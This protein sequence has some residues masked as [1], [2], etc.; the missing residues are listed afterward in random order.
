MLLINWIVVAIFLSPANGIWPFDSNDSSSESVG[1]T[2]ASASNTAASSTTDHGLLGG[3]A[4]FLG[5]GDD[6]TSSTVLVA[7]LSDSSSFTM[8]SYA[9]STLGINAYQPFQTNCPSHKLVREA[10]ELSDQEQEYI[11]GRQEITNTNLIDFLTN[12]ANLTDFDA[13]SFINSYS[14]SHNITIGLTFSGGGY[15]AMLAGAGEIL[16]LDDRFDDSNSH[17]LG[18]LLQSSTYL[19]GLS[20]GNWLVGTLVLN[21][22]ISMADIFDGNISIWDLEDS[23]FNPSGINL[24][25]TVSY[26][27]SIE[28]AILAK[29]DA[30]F[31]T[32]ITDIWGRALSHQ[33]LA[34]DSGGENLTWSSIRDMDNFKNHQMP[35]PIVIAN[36]RT[37]QT[38]I[39][40][41]N[42][43]VFEIS[44]YELGSWDPSLKYFVDTQYLGS[45]LVNGDNKTEQCVMNFDNA[46][47]IMGTSSSLFN[48]IIIYASTSGLPDLVKTVLDK[49]LGSLS[50]DE[51]DIAA[52]SPNPFYGA[53]KAGIQTIVDNSTLFLVDGGEDAQNVP[54]YPLI[55]NNRQVDVI[56][57]FDNS[58]DS[59][60]NWPNCTSI[61]HTYL[62]QFAKQGKGTPFPYVPDVETFLEDEMNQRPY[63]FG[64]NSSD[65]S[66]LL[67]YHNNS[68]INATDIP[69]V[70]N[71]PNSHYSGQS[72]TS[73]FKMS[74]DED[75]RFGMYKNG[76]EVSTRG[77]L[78]ADSNWAK[79]VGCAIIRRSQERLGIEQSDECKDCFSEYC[80]K[81]L[82]ADAAYDEDFSSFV[83]SAGIDIGSP[84]ESSSP[85]ATSSATS[86][87]SG[88]TS[89]STSGSSESTS[90]SS[91]SSDLGNGKFK[92]FSKGLT[93][94]SIIISVL[95]Q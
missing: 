30:G 19:V 3:V 73:T 40:N 78:T 21:D 77:N 32:S 95:I 36:G 5:I 47:F 64:C 92:N 87:A 67:D 46:G 61:V 12:R 15:R 33:F 93:I 59:G 94:I 52:Y 35:F 53:E 79:C 7:T 24:M 31:N 26:Y 41:E 66:T 54:Y 58:A 57:G 83:S 63:F 42:S 37:P 69:L 81:G 60:D 29:A 56:F 85:S 2:S 72:N 17:G 14:S 22:W 23:I 9:S 49:I 74:Y 45:S 86:S 88:S 18:G 39:V 16:A 34:G 20:G 91:S 8:T 68:N 43:T 13:E 4:S 65:L 27:N 6:G 55:Q 62:R 84:L 25:K 70:V 48:Q 51:N 71:I 28:S 11:L 76:F 1:S 89:G 38:F 44:P 82:A 90:A 50:Y 80:W 10:N 75:E